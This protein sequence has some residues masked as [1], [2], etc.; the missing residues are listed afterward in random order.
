MSL[1]GNIQKFSDYWK[2]LYP[3]IFGDLTDQEI[4]D[5]VR[6]NYPDLEIPEWEEV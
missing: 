6:T 3:D 5:E 1:I 2:N 4:V